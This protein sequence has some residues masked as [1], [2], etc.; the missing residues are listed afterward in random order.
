VKRSQIEENPGFRPI[1]LY[2]GYNSFH[3][4]SKINWLVFIQPLT[5]WAMAKCCPACWIRSP[6]QLLR[7]RPYVQDK[8]RSVLIAYY[9]IDDTPAGLSPM[10]RTKNGWWVKEVV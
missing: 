7:S 5:L 4:A 3:A 6:S 9:L 1:V 2:S 10:Y 8:K